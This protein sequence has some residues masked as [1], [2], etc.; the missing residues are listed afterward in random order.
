V[1][2]K[3]VDNKWQFYA[4]ICAGNITPDNIKGVIPKTLERLGKMYDFPE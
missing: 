3:R 4:Q 1:F 2:G